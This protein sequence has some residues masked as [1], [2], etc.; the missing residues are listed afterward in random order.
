LRRLRDAKS[1]NSFSDEAAID[2]DRLRNLDP[3]VTRENQIHRDT[4][5]F[6]L[7]RR[8]QFAEIAIDRHDAIVAYRSAQ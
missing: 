6:G 5:Q 4:P 7:S 2:P 1:L 8:W 3:A